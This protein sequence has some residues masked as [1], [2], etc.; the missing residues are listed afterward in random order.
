MSATK[1]RAWGWAKI[2]AVALAA[3]LVLGTAAF[4]LTRGIGAF[5]DLFG[6][7]GYTDVE[8]KEDGIFHMRGTQWFEVDEE[9]AAA[10]VGDKIQEVNQTIE[11]DGY[12]LTV[13]GFVADANGAAIGWATLVNE[14]GLDNVYLSGD[15]N[16]IKYDTISPDWD[17]AF[18]FVSMRA[19]NE[20]E[21]D[22]HGVLIN[23]AN[24]DGTT[25]EL[26]FY[27][28]SQDCKTPE[29]LEFRMGFSEETWGEIDTVVATDPVAVK[30]VAEAVTCG[31]VDVSP[32]SVR[33][34]RQQA[35]AVD[36]MTLTYADGAQQ[37]IAD[38]NYYNVVCDSA[39]LDGD[40][41]WIPTTLIKSDEI[42]SV[43]LL[44]D[45]GS[46]PTEHVFTPAG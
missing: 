9:K 21:N 29:A 37:V 12:V 40:V 20:G 34:R 27:Y 3:V 38:D 5:Q 45:D 30:S 39:N 24:D 13:H 4:A 43:Y 16:L 8:R 42:A 17:G 7:H 15:G 46:Q 31:I 33:V 18:Q 28:A 14:N 11:H 44:T 32:I 19:A 25:L 10:L 22:N 36:N 26:T 41:L 2:V 35:S 1:G 6:T 23:R